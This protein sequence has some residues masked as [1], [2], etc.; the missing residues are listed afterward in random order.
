MRPSKVGDR[1]PLACGHLNRVIWVS[2]DQQTIAV[3]GALRNCP[4]CCKGSGNSRVSNVYLLST[5]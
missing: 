1:L 4:V 2:E 5:E 3:K